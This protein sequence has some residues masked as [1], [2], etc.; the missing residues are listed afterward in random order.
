M[1]TA[2]KENAKKWKTEKQFKI[3]IRRKL[4]LYQ[5]IEKCNF[6]FIANFCVHVS[7]L[8]CYYVFI[9]INL[10]IYYCLLYA[11]KKIK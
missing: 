10:I 1:L 8:T 3:L 6:I 11:K 9:F 4:P 7:F 2:N 5:Y